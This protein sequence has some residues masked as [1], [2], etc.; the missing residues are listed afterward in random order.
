MGGAVLAYI[1]KKVNPML[2][3]IVS[4]VAIASAAAVFF[5]MADRESVILHIGGFELQWGL[6]AYSW[7]FGAMVISM[8]TLASLY[9]IAYMKGKDRLGY[10]NLNFT[11]SVAAMMGILFSMD[12]ISFFIFWE[13]MTWSSFLIIVYNGISEGK[14][15]IKYMI[16]SAIGGYSMLM[17]MVITK[18]QIDSFLI[19]DLISSFS[20]MSLG[21]QA[22]IGVLFLIAFSVKSAVMPLHVWAP[23]AYADSPMSY[24]SIFSGL[25]SKM[26]VFGL[27]IMLI[28]VFSKTTNGNI[29]IYSEVLAW[30][31]AITGVIATFYAIIQTDAK[32]LLAYSSVAQLGYIVVGLAIGTKLSVMAAL[33]MAIMHAIF[34]GTLFMA[35]G[36]VEKQTGTTDMTKL[37]ALIRKMPLTFVASLMSIIALAGIPPLG[38]FVGKWMLYESMI[39][40]DHYFLII[41]TFLSST[42]AFLYSYRFLFGIFLG[43]EEKEFENVKEAPAIMVVPMILLA[44]SLFFF[45]VFPGYIFEPIANGMEYLGMGQVDWNMTVLS[46]GWGNHVDTL[47]IVNSVLTVFGIAFIFLG[48]KNRKKTR[49]VTTK[50]IHT[51]GEIPTENE[52]LTYAV[53][54]YKPFERAIEPA[55]KRKMDFYYNKFGEGIET[56]FDFVRRLYTGNG[57]TYALYVVIFLVILLIFSEQIF[58]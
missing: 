26:G 40:S 33:F 46:N 45:G 20:S 56:L 16:F 32:R 30:L 48:L 34:K 57:Q 36:A 55:M 18:S 21:L 58:F 2:S 22:L 29:F 6:N 50:D 1:A 10:F 4:F 39:T 51:G 19:A 43:Q 31:G 8:A 41:M 28:S 25:L 35:V 24:T 49:Y 14:I 7:V 37:G 12:W 9:S 5:L 47:S 38:G 13:I 11:L 23:R 17:A 53:D 3:S 54:F 27:G 15:G 42:A 52:N 44:A